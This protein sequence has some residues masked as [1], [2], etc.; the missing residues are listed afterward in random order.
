MR[1]DL[2][3]LRDVAEA[4]ERIDRYTSRGRDAFVGDELI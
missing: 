4:I 1:D 3:R 2:E